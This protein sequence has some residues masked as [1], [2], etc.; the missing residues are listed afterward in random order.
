MRSLTTAGGHGA[1]LT[2]MLFMPRNATVIEFPLA[3]HIDRSFGWTAY[4]LGM[5][6]NIV[7]YFSIASM[8]VVMRHRTT[9]CCHSCERRTC[10][11]TLPLPRPL[12]HLPH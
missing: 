6:R 1:G 9:G 8:A 10:S 2:N 12:K 5:V 4:V 7:I 11:A 3:P